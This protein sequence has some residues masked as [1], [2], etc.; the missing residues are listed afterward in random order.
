MLLN[1]LRERTED[2]ARFGQLALE[3]RGYG[4]AVEHGV[5]SDAR[6]HLLLGDRNAQFLVGAQDLRIDFVEAFQL[7]LLL[8]RRVIGDALIVDRRIVNVR[9]G[10]LGLLGFERRPVAER[11][12]PPVQHELR[13][14]LLSRNQ[15]NSVF[16]QT[17]RDPLFFDVGD[18]SP[19]VF[20]LRQI[21]DCVCV[22]TH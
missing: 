3:C 8:R 4:N 11:L 7:L 6:Q 17:L 18:E 13:L 21:T 5:D 10:R 12:Q 1:S 9:P 19:L 20:L 22:R 14:I 2:H 16:R 15:A